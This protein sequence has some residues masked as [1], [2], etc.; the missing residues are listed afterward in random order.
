M[1][2]VTLGTVCVHVPTA[3][4]AP[5]ALK[6]VQEEPQRHAAVMGRVCPLTALASVTPTQPVVTSLGQRAVRVTHCTTPPTAT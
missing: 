3:T 5:R 1:E 4:G 6:C 2:R